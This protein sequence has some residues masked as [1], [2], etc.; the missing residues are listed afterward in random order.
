MIVNTASIQ[1]MIDTTQSYCLQMIMQISE[2]KKQPPINVIYSLPLS[3]GIKDRL[4][5]IY[6]KN[7][8]I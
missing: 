1:K 4:R 6:D 7:K 8:Q 3:L 5:G 2:I